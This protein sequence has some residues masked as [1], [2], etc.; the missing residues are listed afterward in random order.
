MNLLMRRRRKLSVW[1]TLHLF[2]ARIKESL[3]G[4]KSILFW[5]IAALIVTIEAEVIAGLKSQ[6]R[7]GLVSGRR[8][9]QK[10][11]QQQR[12]A[13]KKHKQK[14]TKKKTNKTN[15]RVRQWNAPDVQNTQ[16][17]EPPESLTKTSKKLQASSD[18]TEHWWS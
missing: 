4:L 7:N 1:V 6:L 10:T 2:A 3:Q 8:S 9:K 12:Q 15:Q 13:P 17:D 11:P 16:Q 14:A 5:T 18:P